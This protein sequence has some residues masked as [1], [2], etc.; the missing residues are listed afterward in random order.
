MES[1][2]LFHWGLGH[3]KIYQQL[4]SSSEGSQIERQEASQ[5]VAIV[6]PSTVR[7]GLFWVSGDFKQFTVRGRCEGHSRHPHTK[8]IYGPTE[9]AR[10]AV[11]LMDEEERKKLENRGSEEV[12]A[13]NLSRD[14]PTQALTEAWARNSRA[15]IDSSLRTRKIQRIEQEQRESQVRALSTLSVLET[16]RRFCEGN[17]SKEV[18]SQKVAEPHNKDHGRMRKVINWFARKLGL[19]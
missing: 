4:E 5:R 19:Q 13:R 3:C 6:K 16:N 11:R 7:S 8:E 1:L 18:Q 12:D 2:P 17:V 10:A 15:Y 9:K 14:E